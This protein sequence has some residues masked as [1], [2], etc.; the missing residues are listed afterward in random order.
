[1]RI[2]IPVWS[3]RVSPVFDVARSVRVVD[4]NDGVEARASDLGLD[5][6]RRAETLA[7]LGVDLLI[8]SAIS[9]SLESTLWMA[10]VEVIPDICGTVDEII[11]AYSNGETSLAKFRSPG[12]SRDPG[13]RGI[14]LPIHG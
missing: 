4:L 10:G 11:T 14:Y 7:K 9:T 3:G 6:D 13:S 1:M 2:A 5:D 8:C 12:N